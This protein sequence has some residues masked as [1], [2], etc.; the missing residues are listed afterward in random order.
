MTAPVAPTSG[1]ITL[2]INDAP[3]LQHWFWRVQRLAWGLLAL[4][5]VAAVAGLTGGA[6]YFADQ[7]AQ[8]PA[9]TLEAPSIMRRLA[10]AA[11]T[12]AVTS[13]APQAVVQ[14]DAAFADAFQILAMTPPPVSAFA[15]PEGAAYRF[16][17][18]GP[19]SKRLHFQIESDNSGRAAYSIFTDGHRARLSTWVLP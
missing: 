18:S 19:G 15:T 11:I 5:A 14:F 9:F 16:D 10:N 2:D 6:G 17:L 3:R 13:D 1:T 12:I 7:T 4:L 8:G